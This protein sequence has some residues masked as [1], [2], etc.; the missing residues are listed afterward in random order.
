MSVPRTATFRFEDALGF[1]VNRAALAVR[2]ELRRRVR[3]NGFAI[4]PEL[5]GDAARGISSAD[6]ATT[7]RTLLRVFDNLT[8]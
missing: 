6:L 5:L 3:A 8:R 4:A 1:S 2:A 7:H